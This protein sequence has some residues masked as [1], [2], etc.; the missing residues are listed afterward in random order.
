VHRSALTSEK[1][2]LARL[3]DQEPNFWLGRTKLGRPRFT[4]DPRDLT[5]GYQSD[6]LG[7]WRW[8][9]SARRWLMPRRGAVRVLA[10]QADP[11]AG[12]ADHQVA[13]LCSV[14]VSH[15][16]G[17]ASRPLPRTVEAARLE[18]AAPCLEAISHP[19]HLAVTARVPACS[20]VALP[21]PPAIRVP[22]L[23][24]IR[25]VLNQPPAVRA[26]R[27]KPRG[28]KRV[29]RHSSPLRGRQPLR[30]ARR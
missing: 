2:A 24:E 9:T 21:S 17:A 13:A 23:R 6:S 10:G 3:A 18:P 14:A 5:C 7:C 28:G 19:Q 8:L 29:A 1:S 22:W 15:R 30:G 11:V 12:R 26:P 20:A 25:R 4:H 16:A 27:H